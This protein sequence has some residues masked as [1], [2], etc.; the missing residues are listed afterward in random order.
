MMTGVKQLVDLPESK[1]NDMDAILENIVRN[2]GACT[3]PTCEECPWSYTG[4]T[5]YFACNVT[6]I[7]ASILREAGD[8]VL[9][10]IVNTAGYFEQR[11]ND[12]D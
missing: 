1:R 11:Q 12:E 8:I 7:G 2:N 10:S 3:R 9:T 6:K 4:N 5:A